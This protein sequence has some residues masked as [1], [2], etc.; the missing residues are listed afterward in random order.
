MQAIIFAFI[1]YFGW[2]VGDI[3]GAI[4]TRKIGPY[5][6]AFWVSLLGSLIFTLY[7][8][9]DLARLNQLTY[10][11]LLLNIFLGLIFIIGSVCLNE[12]FRL[13]NVS[14]TGTIIS[15]YAALTVVLSILFLHETVSLSQAVAIVIIS[16]G[17]LLSTLDFADLKNRKLI[18]DHGIRLAWLAMISYGIYFAFIKIVVK[19]IG[20]FWP[21]YITFLLFPLIYLYSKLQGIALQKPTHKNALLPMIVCTFLLRIGDFSFNLGISKGLTAIVAP[22]AGAYP[23]LLAVLGFLVFKDPIKRQQIIG[24]VVTLVGIVFLS[25]ISI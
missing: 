19:E 14:L 16:G 3:F 8:P 7:V 18:T 6:T 24:I 13:S 23:T 4:T 5:A 25:I 12:A 11:V 1:S 21:N 17:I 20:W 22:I 15:S 9:F 10:S 2:G